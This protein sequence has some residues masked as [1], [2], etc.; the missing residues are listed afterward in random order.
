MVELAQ[1]K[2]A[3]YVPASMLGCVTEKETS[4]AVTASL[5][6]M[7]T[8]RR[9]NSL[10]TREL[11]WEPSSPIEVTPSEYEK[12]VVSWLEEAEGKLAGFSVQHLEKLRGGAGEYVIDAVAKFKIF[13]GAEIAVLVECKKLK[14]PVERD[15]V[16]ILKGKMQDTGSHKG[17]IF[18]TSGFQR[19]AIEY[20]AK[21]GIALITFVDGRHTYVTR[22]AEEVPHAFLPADLPKYAGF[23]ATP[24][25]TGFS[26]S[27]ISTRGVDKLKQW[28]TH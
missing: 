21:Q 16:M 7:V 10:M 9:E 27:T 14:R 12:Q 4:V 20:A 3:V 19:G 28:L 24:T 23:W 2:A 8:R 6:W 11:P 15:V 13:E 22:S 17:I 5:C 1:P 25:D 18:S 26:V